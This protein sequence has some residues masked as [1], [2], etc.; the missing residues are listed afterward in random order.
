MPFGPGVQLLHSAGPDQL[1]RRVTAER[2]EM[3]GRRRGQRLSLAGPDRG[4]DRR[5]HVLTLQEMQPVR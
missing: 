5:R 3:D 2:I 1:S 4:H